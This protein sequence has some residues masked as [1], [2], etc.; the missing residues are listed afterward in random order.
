MAAAMPAASVNCVVTSPPN[1][2]LR[3]YRVDGQYGAESTVDEYVARLVG[4]FDQGSRVLLL[5]GTLWQRAG[6]LADALGET[7][8]VV[9][10]PGR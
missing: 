3:D 10:R 2:G 8:V 7:L 4:L 1:W 9:R 5:D 6:V